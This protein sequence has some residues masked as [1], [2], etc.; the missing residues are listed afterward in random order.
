M[1]KKLSRRTL[2]ALFLSQVRALAANDLPQCVWYL[3]ERQ[4]R[5]ILF[6]ASQ[7]FFEKGEIPFLP[8]LP[9][10]YRSFHD[11][12]LMLEINSMQGRNDTCQDACIWIDTSYKHRHPWY[13]FNVH[14]GDP[15]NGKSIR[16]HLNELHQVGR[17]PLLTEEVIALC[18]H[19][20]PR[21]M[22]LYCYTPHSNSWSQS[23]LLTGPAEDGLDGYL[24][25][26]F[27]G[28]T[29]YGMTGDMDSSRKVL[30]IP[31]CSV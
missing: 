31:S 29:V 27:K 30:R 1:S 20:K 8:I 25:E 11:Q 10:T 6:S 21:N 23:Y 15:L 18:L 14:I 16:E 12:M 17:R 22:L 28:P 7:M 13:I 24:A 4:R 26:H 5:D 19:N 3:F 2:S 9:F